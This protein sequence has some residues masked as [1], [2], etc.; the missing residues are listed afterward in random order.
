MV[1]RGSQAV[2]SAGGGLG[3]ALAAALSGCMMAPPPEPV[4]P[5]TAACPVIGDGRWQ[6]WLDAMPGPGD[7]R[8]TLNIAGEVDLPTP[9]WGL[10]LVPGPA[11]RMMPPSQR[12]RLEAS[13]PRG[14]GAQV[15][16]P[17]TV[18]YREKASYPA[19]RSIIVLCG[20]RALATITDIPTV[21]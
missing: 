6:A 2:K 13:K 21:R 7:G 15:V 20:D 10:R 4:G 1:R 11:D 18:K 9:G 16:T 8:P 17:M 5:V 3:L 14:M 19:Y 12:F